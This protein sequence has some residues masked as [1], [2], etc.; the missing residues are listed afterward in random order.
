[1]DHP[2]QVQQGRIDHKLFDFR[3]S[4]SR[5]LR[6]PSLGNR[7]K[8][9]LSEYEEGQQVQRD[10]RCSSRLDVSVAE[11]VP[12]NVCWPSHLESLVERLRIQSVISR[13][14]Y[15]LR[16][17]QVQSCRFGSVITKCVICSRVAPDS[18]QQGSACCP[19]GPLR[20]MIPCSFSTCLDCTDSP[21][22]T[23]VPVGAGAK[24]EKRCSC[25]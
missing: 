25:G 8:H 16:F 11:A 22:I 3:S 21:A 20:T 10:E 2:A 12:P 5:D 9:D 17:R 4:H 18:V 23:H 14:G 13:Y 19:S 6:R 15:C 24:S 7:L 1:M